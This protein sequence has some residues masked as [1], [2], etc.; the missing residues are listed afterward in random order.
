MF[1]KVSLFG[2]IVF[3]L[4]AGKSICSAY[5]ML[6]TTDFESGVSL[7]WNISESNDRNS[8]G[9]VRDGQYVV[10]MDYP[11]ENSWDVQIR[12]RELSIIAGQKYFV[13]FKVTAEKSCKIYAKIGDKG[14]PYW[15]A[16]NNK[17]TAF[18]IDANKI[19]EVS[20]TFVAEKNST[21]AEFAFH[22]G[23]LLASSM[24]NEVKFISMSLDTYGPPP[25]T[26]PKEPER[27][28]R[29][30]QIGYL[31]DSFKKATLN[32]GKNESTPIKWELRNEAG[33]AE[34]KGETIPFGL[35]KA[36]GEYVHTIDFSDFKTEGKGYS[37]VTEFGDTSYTFDIS[38]SIYSQMKYDA[39]KYF[40]HARS[41]IEIKMPYCVD[42]KWARGAGHVPDSASPKSGITSAPSQINATGGWYDGGD[43]GKH[44]VTGGLALWLLQNQYERSG[45]KEKNEYLKDGSLNIPESRNGINDLLDETRWEMD[46]ML[47]L[48][49]PEGY[50]QEGMVVHDIRDVRMITFGLV[51]SEDIE[52]RTFT[53]PTTAATLNLAACGAQ[54]ARIWKNI[55][56]EYSE[57]CLS[58]AEK[59]YS[60][61]KANPEIFPYIN[62]EVEWDD[63]VKDE[64]YW[65]A[66][67]LYLT[68]GKSEYLEDLGKYEKALKTSEYYGEFGNDYKTALGTI[69]LAMLK[70]DEFPKAVDNIKKTADGYLEN[71][72]KE[73]YGALATAYHWYSNQNIISKSIILAYAYDLSKDE[74]YNQGI[75]EALDYLMGRNPNSKSYVSGYGEKPLQNPYHRFFCPQF[76]PK[77]PSVPSGFLASGPNS[78]CVD[79]W[80]IGSGFSKDIT[81]PQKCY[82]DHS[83]S[84]STNEVSIALNASLAWI[85]SYVDG[86]NSQS[87][88]EEDLDQD[89]F[90]TMGDVM[91]IAKCFNAEVGDE[92]YDEKC[93]L[94][95]D[96]AINMIDVVRIAKVFGYNKS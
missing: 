75:T 65:A 88:M 85:T 33:E 63:C 12:H 25:P 80:I 92:R 81:P 49:I 23:G 70:P 82:I 6:Q 10:H 30:N 22:I 94:N 38:N 44:V 56:A 16:W 15:E 77:L 89:G 20:D 86:L 52:K 87:I 69:S 93:D 24:P 27:M 39:L 62:S 37:L 47:N 57:R 73:G 76:D 60:A 72:K 45:I 26:I 53:S 28:I 7:P 21:E 48:Q 31:P 51:A 90:I 54:A 61:A 83:E 42:T 5:E 34:Y 2:T 13:K 29:V 35:D 58:A 1:K 55:D 17:W 78:D 79:P 50:E 40:Y 46:W 4:I 84:W 95:K 3:V 43:Y 18:N 8:Y 66:C 68:T 71:Q 64:F 32:I 14:A 74:K 9:V 91:K 59:A 96:G 19:L 11:G 36:S 67:E 41:G